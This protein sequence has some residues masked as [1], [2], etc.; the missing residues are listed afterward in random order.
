[1]F[2]CRKSSQDEGKQ[3]SRLKAAS[4]IDKPPTR[5]GLGIV[6]SPWRRNHS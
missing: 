3:K 2:T 1:M 6:L 5:R 4:K